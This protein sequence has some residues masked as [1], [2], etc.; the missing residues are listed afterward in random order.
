MSSMLI[1]EY[2]IHMLSYNQLSCWQL[3]LWCTVSIFSWKFSPLMKLMSAFCLMKFQTEAKSQINIYKGIGKFSHS[4]GWVI[5]ITIF[6]HFEPTVTW[7][8]VVLYIT[9]TIWILHQI[10]SVIYLLSVA[11]SSSELSTSAMA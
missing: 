2:W 10:L 8:A 11:Q 9:V 1:N 6:C 5:G 3:N 7:R 4:F